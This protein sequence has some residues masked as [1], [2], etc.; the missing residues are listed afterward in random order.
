RE[1][2]TRVSDHGDIGLERTAD[3]R[4]IKVEMDERLPGAERDAKLFEGAVAEFC[5]HSEH[6]VGGL[7]GRGR[8]APVRQH[9][10]PHRIALV[11]GAAATDRRNDRRSQTSREICQLSL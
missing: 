10:V 3:D 2:I 8:R 11:D 7:Q 5:A 9:A 6:D 1:T 4:W